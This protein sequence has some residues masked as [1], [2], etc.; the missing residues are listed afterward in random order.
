ME[1]GPAREAAAASQS[2]QTS[3]SQSAALETGTRTR[4]GAADKVVAVQ[5]DKAVV[6]LVGRAVAEEDK[7]HQKRKVLIV[8]KLV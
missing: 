6:A 8:I 5:V 1:R 4:K 3:Q 7:P 2:T